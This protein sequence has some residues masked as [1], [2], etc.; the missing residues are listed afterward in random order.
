[1]GSSYAEKWWLESAESRALPT[2]PLV[3]PYAPNVYF[4]GRDAVNAAGAV[5][6]WTDRITAIVATSTDAAHRPLID[7]SSTSQAVNFD[8]P[9]KNCFGFT[10]ALAALADN[11][12]FTMSA[13]VKL[14]ASSDPDGRQYVGALTGPGLAL[15]RQQGPGRKEQTDRGGLAFSGT[16][17]IA[18]NAWLSYLFT[19]DGAQGTF[20]LDAVG[21][22]PIA[23]PNAVVEPFA[24]HLGSSA[25]NT[26]AMQGLL[27]D[28]LVWARVLTSD[29]ITGM[30]TYD[31]GLW[32]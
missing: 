29:E 24:V 2:P 15:S 13:R 28:F 16:R 14:T 18:S 19:Y 8:T 10:S 23:Q 30:L 31:A 27:G 22:A 11:G 9:L 32:S 4:D 12:P 17:A 7:L 3:A 1:V 20:Y 21:E 5:S 6:S 25:F 26:L